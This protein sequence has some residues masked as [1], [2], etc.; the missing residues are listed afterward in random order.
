MLSLAGYFQAN[1]STLFFMA[2][3]IL[4]NGLSKGL[5]Q[6]RWHPVMVFVCEKLGGGVRMHGDRR[7]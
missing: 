3:A 7:Q 2:T 6:N 5:V 4:R 1:M